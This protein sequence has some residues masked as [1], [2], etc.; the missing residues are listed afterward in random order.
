MKYWMCITNEDNWKI[1]R[2]KRVWG[3]PENR[4]CQIAEVMP[5]DNL[6]FYLKPKRVVGIYLVETSFFESKETM[7]KTEGFLE[8]EKFPFRIKIKPLFVLNEPL[9]F[10]PFVKQM[11]FI[12]NKERWGGYFFG[13][14]MFQIS[15]NDFEVIKS[16]F[17]KTK[18]V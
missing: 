4:R 3:V 18:E 1:I 10:L 15:S 12:N 17:K 16:E 2:Q 8:K 13:R 6:I 7:F 5:K 14:A 11:Q 9:N